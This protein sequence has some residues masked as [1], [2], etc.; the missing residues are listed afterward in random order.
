MDTDK[1]K[2][3]VKPMVQTVVIMAVFYAVEIAM[4]YLDVFPEYS[5]LIIADIVLKIILGT[6]ALVL[7]HRYSVRGESKCTVKQLFTNKITAKTW[8]V[9]IPFIIY[10]MLPFVKLFTAYAF[11]TE[12]LGLLCLIIFQQFAVGFYEETVQRSLF[13]NGLI[14]LNTSTVKQR[15]C[16]V[17]IAGALFGLGHFPNIAFGENPLAQCPATFLWG[18]FIAAVYMLSDNLLLVIILHA[19]SDSTFRIVKGLFGFARDSF[20]CQSLDRVSSVIEFVILPV[21]AI[22]ICVFYDRLKSPRSNSKAA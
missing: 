15:L 12:V 2:A 13:M 19:L 4:V 21:M 8:L 7:L 1:R 20:F 18:M 16:T 5:T 3:I 9:L 6:V 17:L 22:L 10:I 14:K 11:T